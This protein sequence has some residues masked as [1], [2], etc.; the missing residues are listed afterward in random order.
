MHLFCRKITLVH[1]VLNVDVFAAACAAAAATEKRASQRQ[2]LN[3]PRRQAKL[4]RRMSSDNT[5]VTQ[6]LIM[7]DFWAKHFNNRHSVPWTE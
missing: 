1:S 3:K 5:A 7:L 2:S 4:V 6:Q